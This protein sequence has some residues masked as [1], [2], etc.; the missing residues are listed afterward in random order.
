MSDALRFPPPGSH[1]FSEALKREVNASFEAS[2]SSIHANG[3]MWIKVVLLPLGAV[4]AWITL[5]FVPLPP[6]VALALCAVLGVF[7]AAVGMAVGH[8]ALHGSLSP[9]PWVNRL[10]GLSFELIGANS[11]IWRYTHNRNHHLYT[12][13]D[14]VDLDLDLAPFLATTPGVPRR[15]VHRWQPHGARAA[16]QRGPADPVVQQ[17]DL[18]PD[19]GPVQP[20]L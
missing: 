17:P 4:L 5:V 14:G 11:Y 10:V 7:I 16:S 9:R 8:D 15:A 3:V 13:L 20:H 2:G 18:R 1:P 6:V 19:Q 12:N